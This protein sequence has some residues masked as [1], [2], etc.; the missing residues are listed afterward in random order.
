MIYDLV[1]QYCS[2]CIIVFLSRLNRDLTKI[3]WAWTA[4]II[5]VVVSEHVKNRDS[6]ARPV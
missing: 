3:K 4:K 6:A 2:G 5:E 1:T